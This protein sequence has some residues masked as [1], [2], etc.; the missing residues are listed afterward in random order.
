MLD[1]SDDVHR[2]LS[3]VAQ[4]VELAIW[5]DGAIAVRLRG[6][7]LWTHFGVSG[8]VALDASRHWLR[9]QLEGR[10]VA[11]HHQ[12]PPRRTFDDVDADWTRQ[13]AAHPRA[14]VQTDARA[15]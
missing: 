14:S 4:D 2:E 1:A 12:L 15:R 3:G 10:A 13:A 8:P 5:I 6:A 11:D 9:A 7:M